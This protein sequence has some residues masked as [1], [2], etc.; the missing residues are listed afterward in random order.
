MLHRKESDKQR[1]RNR[2][3]HTASC[4]ILYEFWKVSFNRAEGGWRELTWEAE[5][6][7]EKIRRHQDKS[8]IMERDVRKRKT[9]A[10]GQRVEHKTQ[11]DC[12]GEKRRVDKV[13]GEELAGE[14]EMWV[15]AG[16]NQ[17]LSSSKAV[18][19]VGGSALISLSH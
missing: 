17:N 5:G 19:G 11:R 13:R 12:S 3:I 1:L 4:P 15:T 8:E 16:L 14:L 18:E 9:D 6:Y 2:N 10:D 7:R